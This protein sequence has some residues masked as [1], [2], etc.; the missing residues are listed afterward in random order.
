MKVIEAVSRRTSSREF[1]DGH[2]GGRNAQLVPGR[3][4]PVGCTGRANLA[5]IGR[6]VYDGMFALGA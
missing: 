4:R 6:H 2:D 5:R 1:G 3:T